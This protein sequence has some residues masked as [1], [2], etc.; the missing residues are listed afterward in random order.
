M[1]TKEN[2]IALLPPE[3]NTNTGLG[4]LSPFPP[5]HVR[6]RPTILVQID[7]FYGS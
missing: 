3:L 5:N 1:R 7:S 6:Q 4:K 2:L